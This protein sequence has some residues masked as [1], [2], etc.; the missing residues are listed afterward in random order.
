MKNRP[1][2]GKALC[3][4][5]LAV[6]FSL[7][8]LLSTA[9]PN[10][11]LAQDASSS[12]MPAD[13]ISLYK[14]AGIDEKQQ[15]K[16]LALANQYEETED[17]KAHEMIAYLKN[18][19]ALSLVPDLDEKQILETQT[20]I[21]KLQSEMALDRMHL[22]IN[23]RRILNHDQ[24]IKLVQLMQQAR[25][26]GIHHSESASPPPVPIPGVAMPGTNHF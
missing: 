14:E 3:C 20:D 18:L 25:S 21:N 23:I 13:P 12:Q 19:R 7:I 2:T 5:L 16:V 1:V 17:K 22:L 15:V 8:N 9:A 10:M 6:S 4:T 11:V 24:R 26:K